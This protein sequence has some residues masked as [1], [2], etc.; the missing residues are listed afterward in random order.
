MVFAGANNLLDVI[1]QVVSQSNGPTIGTQVVQRTTADIG[2]TLDILESMGA[3]HVLVPN[4]PS[5]GL[6]PQVT[7]QG[8]HTIAVVIP[9]SQSFNQE[10]DALI[11]AETALHIKRLDTFSL[12]NDV[13]ANPTTFGLSNVT[14]PCYSE[15]ATTFF[16]TGS[17]CSSP[18]SYLF[19][20]SLHPTTA[21]H[22]IFADAALNAVG[23]P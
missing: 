12:L 3:R 4:A 5:L 22:A 1:P 13:A 8:P 15:N 9:L 17:V 21:G 11:S 20:D 19:W 7:N 10:L 23:Q 18:E 14:S 16:R 2:R 6:V